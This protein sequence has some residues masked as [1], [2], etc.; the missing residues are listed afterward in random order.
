MVTPCRRQR[1]VSRWLIVVA[2]LLVVLII[3]L[4][5]WRR[6]GE[7]HDYSRMVVELVDLSG[8][9]PKPLDAIETGDSLA[10]GFRDLSPRAPV[11]IYLRDDQG[12][13]WSYARTT[14]DL[15]GAIEPTLFWYHTGVIGTTSRKINFKP[16]PAFRTFEEAE[17][18]WEKHPLRLTITDLKGR[19]VATKD[20]PFRKKASPMVYP[21][22]QE[23]VLMNSF[24]LS[25][26][27]IYATG[28]NFPAGATVQLFTVRNQYA[29][30]LG[31]PLVDVTGR[32][33]AAEIDTVRLGPAQTSFTVKIWDRGRVRP[34]SFD[35]VARLAP[36]PGELVLKPSDILSYG[37]DTGMILYAIING[38]IVIESAG[39]MRY[40]PAK[41][42]FSDSF[43]KGENIYGAVDPSDVPAVHSGGNYA[44]YYVVE[45]QPVS[46]WDGPN[47][48]LVDVSGGLPEIQR[49]K[50]WCINVS[51]RLI[52]A[53]AT[54]TDPIK[55]YDVI[56]DFGSVPAM[57]STQYTPDNTYTKGT[58]FIDGYGVDAGFWLFE[59][60][61]STGTFAVGQVELNDPNGISGITDPTG[62]TGPTYNVTL[63][64]ARIMYPATTAGTGTPVS[65]A[66]PNYPVALFL[67]GR[68][69][70][71]DADGS[72]PGLSGSYSY[73]CAAA[74]RIPSHEGYNYIMERL[75]SQGIFSISISAHDIQP[76][77]SVW[78]YDARGRLILKFLDKLRDWTTND[79]DPFGG[80]F[81]GK[82]DMT[83]IALSGHSRGG[84]GVV[85]AQQLN[86]TWPTPYSILAVNAIAPTDQ[87]G[88]SY[89]MTNGAYLLLIGARDGD[90]A[91]MQGFRT[92]DR[93]YP[94]GATV[95][96]AKSVAWVHGANHN[97]FNTIW[98]DAAALGGP[99]P[100]AGQ[101]D[102]G[103]T[104]TVSQ[105]LTAAQQRQS[106]LTTIAAFFRQHLQNIPPYKEIFTGRL[107]AAAMPN[108]YVFWTYQDESRKAVDNFEQT[109]L[110]ASVN[111]L[112]GM[113]TAPGFTVFEERLL[114][115]NSTDYV[116]VF[117][118]DN[119][120][121]HD[122][123]GLKLAW[124][125]PQTYTTTIPSGQ[126]DVSIYTHLT[127]RAAKKVT[128]APTT[129]P[130]VNLHV[131]IEDGNGKK[132]LW[133]LR[134]DQFD[135]IPH[136]YQRSGG[137][138][139]SDCSNQAQ[140]VGVR[141][142][143]RNFTMNNSGVDL[144]NIVKITIRVE[145]SGEI[146][147]DDIEFGK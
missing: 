26:D 36:Q 69:V 135:A 49:V 97:Y 147:L 32:D 27:E 72:G 95:R 54:Q 68:H 102:D 101:T 106:A 126:G 143:L 90:V 40:A 35:I 19:V 4:I 50:Y 31:D 100:W 11:Q 59:D 18:Y 57:D 84:E 96:R 38:N 113:V 34:G 79:T 107:K 39:R 92:Y 111:T 42:E 41:F 52:W 53:N 103:G 122:T 114:N 74:N 3:L 128:G 7:H 56:V 25:Q 86:Q 94:Q 55:A 16:D 64:W 98:T 60:P 66:L 124:S 81:N 2:V 61:S 28:R 141:I 120:F 17:A 1:G 15:K 30:S 78:N 63:A 33:G 105:T 80:I 9:S 132:A 10:I 75:A 51:R 22:N 37:E 123:L 88:A 146:G 144:S 89:L 125:A 70:N 115:Y 77:N 85:A 110:N 118:T 119:K 23:G 48:S 83:R 14:A 20:I 6:R 139:G 108:Q 76:D 137:W 43:E 109:P 130:G 136:P 58:D 21:S 117:A 8:P 112:T 87:N 47:P 46:Y 142:P 131:N 29:W 82:L 73:T 93:A 45:H 129:G 67:H 138:C 44:A 99:N 13:E 121:F 71:C 12:R 127:L 62:M 104:L 134:T 116:G 24:D 65:G 140:L 133:D 5:L 145:G 91:T